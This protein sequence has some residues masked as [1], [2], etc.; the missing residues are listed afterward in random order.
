MTELELESLLEHA[1]RAGPAPELKARL[2]E[3]V[4]LAASAGVAVTSVASASHAAGS[5]VAA[6]AKSSWLVSAA[7]SLALGIGAGAV[8][9]VPLVLR[10]TSQRMQPVASAK[11]VSR[12]A[13]SAR[14]APALRTPNITDMR[15]PLAS[16]AAHNSEAT[17]P[18]NAAPGLPSIQ[19]ETELLTEAQGALQRGEPRAALNALNRYDAEVKSGALAEEALA[20][21]AM[22][23]CALLPSAAGER[24]YKLFVARYANSPLLPR[25]QTGCRRAGP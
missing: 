12:P 25:V 6:G 17:P 2:R 14:R 10:E 21:R 7:V 8:V 22:A 9:T 4:L 18:H 16:S 3:R 5:V 23:E 24:S 19:R 13:Q 11:P 20:V 15:A 1:K